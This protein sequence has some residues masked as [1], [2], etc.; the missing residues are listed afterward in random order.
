[1]IGL[2]M[3]VLIYRLFLTTATFQG[4]RQNHNSPASQARQASTKTW[5]EEDIF[6]NQIEC[7]FCASSFASR[8]ALFRH[9]RTDPICSLAANDGTPDD[10]LLRTTIRHMLACQFSYWGKNCEAGVAGLV[11]GETIQQA[12]RDYMMDTL[13]MTNTA[14]EP[15][16][17]TQSS[18]TKMRHRSLSQEKGCASCGDVMILSLQA[19]AA[20]N[21]NA[22]GMVSD[23]HHRGFLGQILRRS[24][25]ILK[26]TA[27][28]DLQVR[29][30]ACKYLAPDSRLHAERSC[31]QLVY[32]YLLPLQWLPDGLELEKWWLENSQQDANGH[33]NRASQRPPNESLRLMKDALRSGESAK[34]PPLSK[35]SAD[36][37]SIKVATGRFGALGTKE[38][39]PWHNYADPHLKGDASPNNEPVWRVLDRARMVRFMLDPSGDSSDQVVA[40]LE[41]RGDGFLREQ[42]RRIVGTAVAVAH[43]WLPTDV[44]Q[45][46]TTPNSF[47]ETPIAPMGRLYL[48]ETRFHFDEM[49][50][51]GKS[52]FESDVMGVSARSEWFDVSNELV[53]RHLLDE[54]NKNNRSE[55][56][57]LKDLENVVAPRIR[58]QLSRQLGTHHPIGS[59]SVNSLIVPVIYLRVVDMLR[60][61]IVAGTWPET[62]AARSS[63]I[64]NV[65]GKG[66][67]EIH[68]EMNQN[69]SFTVVNPKFQDGRYQN[70]IG[71]DSLPLGN[72]LFPA[73]VDAVFQLESLLAESDIE[74]AEGIIGTPRPQRPGSSHCAIN[75]NAQFAPHVDSGR[76]AGQSLSMIVGLGDYIGGDLAVEGDNFDIR[77]HPLEFNGWKLRHW[78]NPFAGERFS[79]V[80]FTPEQKGS[81]LIQ[82]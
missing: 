11:V 79:L 10:R 63:V 75:A 55:A 47:I 58:G 41:F 38:R 29:L 57:W 71:S 53:E 14:V 78:T 82:Q 22:V 26:A 30:D 59:L 62:S 24:N 66:Q 34:L 13:N 42:V 40:L 46:S 36:N 77:Y 68:E 15:I 45:L 25:T 23:K 60:A 31:T 51:D 48:A 56:K 54:C 1:M 49:R 6:V 70:G 35:D 44:F 37:L 4:F 2:V 67:S 73:L 28:D 27:T 20:I 76:G 80:W 8:N 16:S 21:A 69:G 43:G 64:T 81:N 50:S 74:Q 9:V 39:R 52:L 18:V 19:P 33:Q 7:K 17:S 32:H 72:S 12:M 3:I 61:I 65:I 5:K